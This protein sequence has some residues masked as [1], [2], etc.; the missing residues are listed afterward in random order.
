MHV[1]VAL[2][3]GVT[4]TCC[5]PP[6][7]KPDWIT[8]ASVK[9]L[10]SLGID[11]DRDLSVRGNYHW[12]WI[13]RGELAVGGFHCPAGSSIAVSRTISVISSPGPATCR[14]PAGTEAN[15]LELHD[16]GTAEPLGSP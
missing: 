7:K 8:D 13:S 9:Q 3:V 16:D 5:S 14:G 10:R 15:F 2:A 12:Q 11:P 6:P 4:L 1:A